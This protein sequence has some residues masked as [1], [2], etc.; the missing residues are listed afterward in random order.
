MGFAGSVP[1]D[2]VAEI[3]TLKHLEEFAW[4]TA[5]Q[6]EKVTMFMDNYYVEKNRLGSKCDF[7]RCVSF[8][9]SHFFSPR[10][11]FP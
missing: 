1:V 11:S 5:S 7:P 2:G 3:M 10:H 4:L 9:N 6:A 8:A